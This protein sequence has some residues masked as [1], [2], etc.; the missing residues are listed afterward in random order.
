MK[1]YRRKPVEVEAIQFQNTD[2]SYQELSGEVGSRIYKSNNNVFFRRDRLDPSKDICLR[3]GHWIIITRRQVGFGIFQD[4]FEVHGDETFK[5]KFEIIEGD[6]GN[7][8]D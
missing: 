8:S 3:K 5:E 1:R 2:E 6:D 4:L 7:N